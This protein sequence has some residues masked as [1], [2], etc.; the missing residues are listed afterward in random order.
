MILIIGIITEILR[1]VCL[2]NT[3]NI[4]NANS[5]SFGTLLHVFGLMLVTASTPSSIMLLICDAQG[6]VEFLSFS[7]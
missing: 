7:P 2:L 6:F 4:S 3:N 5:R 1:I